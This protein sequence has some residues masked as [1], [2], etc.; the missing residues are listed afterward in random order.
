YVTLNAGVSQ[1]NKRSAFVSEECCRH[2]LSY[3]HKIYFPV[4]IEICEQRVRDH[5]RSDQ[6][7]TNLLCRHGKLATLITQQI[8]YCGVR[9]GR[10]HYPTADEQVEVAIAIPIGRANTG[11]ARPYRRQRGR[12]FGEPASAVIDKQPVL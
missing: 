5:S 12:V 3:H 11:G 6:L 8:A 1:P 7:R 4:T 9:P 2:K 10:R